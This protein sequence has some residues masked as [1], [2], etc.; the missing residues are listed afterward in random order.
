MHGYTHTQR[1]LDSFQ[2]LPM[3]FRLCEYF[4]NI[5]WLL[6]PQATGLRV[7][8]ARYSAR[9]SRHV[10][11]VFSSS[12]FPIKNGLHTGACVCTSCFPFDHRGPSRWNF[13]S[14]PLS[15]FGVKSA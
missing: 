9:L 14:A 5:A 7:T 12:A 13:D 3:S 10:L 15:S 8:H 1:L 11:V 6:I 2:G 4:G